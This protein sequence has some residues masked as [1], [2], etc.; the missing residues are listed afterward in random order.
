M[1]IYLLYATGTSSAP[2]AALVDCCSPPE[3]QRCSR[4]QW[5]S[6]P[7]RA[8]ASH[9]LQTA[10]LSRCCHHDSAIPASKA[11]K[12]AAPAASNDARI[13]HCL[14]RP[15]PCR[16]LDEL[17]MMPRFPWQLKRSEWAG[18]RARAC[19]TGVERV[20]YPWIAAD[21]AEREAVRQRRGETSKRAGPGAKVAPDRD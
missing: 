18:P 13:S 1:R 11:R 21:T 2:A 7:V 15:G 3:C 9:S 17:S 5:L 8:A 19:K 12:R 10:S 14:N 4:R 6:E 16:R 20:S